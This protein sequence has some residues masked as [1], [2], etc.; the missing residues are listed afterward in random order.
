MAHIRTDIRNEIAAR[1]DAAK[2]AGWRVEKA[3][4][5]RP[6]FGQ[7][8]AVI[9]GAARETAVRGAGCQPYARTIVFEF[10]AYVAPAADVDDAIDA[11]SVWIERVLDADPKLGGLAS[12]VIYR[13]AEIT[14]H[15]GGDRPVGELSLT[16]E[17]RA[18]QALASF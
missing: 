17:I 13:S 9:F 11:A 18:Q 5:R 12:D 8:P 4:D 7:M 1:L 14:V 10:T 15:T 3:R 6:D 16:Y 2:P